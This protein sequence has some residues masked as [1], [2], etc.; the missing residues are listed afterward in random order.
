MC[1]CVYIYTIYVCMC[2]YMYLSLF[3]YLSNLY[4]IRKTRSVVGNLE[5][6]EST[7]HKFQLR[8]EGLRTRRADG[9]SS[10]PG[11]SSKAGEGQCPRL[12]DRQRE[13]SFLLSLFSTQDLSEWWMRTTT[14]ERAIRYT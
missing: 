8:T 4:K 9:V 2:M 13:N 10:S 14:L 7:W 5:T 3:I 11:P 1:V 12:K 6:Q